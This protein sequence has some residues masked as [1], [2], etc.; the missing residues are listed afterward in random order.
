MW[1]W[2][3]AVRFNK[4]LSVDQPIPTASNQKISSHGPSS[5]YVASDE[6]DVYEKRKEMQ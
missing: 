2:L 4:L 1:F 5:E 3:S 6:E